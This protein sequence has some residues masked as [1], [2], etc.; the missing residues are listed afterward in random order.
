MSKQFTKIYEV[1]LTRQQ[2]DEWLKNHPNTPHYEK[3]VCTSVTCDQCGKSIPDGSKII[4]VFTGHHGW[5]NDSS[6]SFKWHELCS[7]ECAQK[8]FETFKELINTGENC[9]TD[10]VN[11]EGETIHYSAL[12]DD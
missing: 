12:G 8:Y 6:E 9:K 7:V 2:L 11:F 3:E 4:K 10:F 1:Y 5:G